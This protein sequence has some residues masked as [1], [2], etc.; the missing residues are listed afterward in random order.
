MNT[1]HIYEVRLR[2]ARTLKLAES[3]VPHQEAARHV[4]QT[5]IGDAD[6][7][8]F[9]AIFLD[10][11][12]KVTGAHVVAIGGQARIGGVEVRTV[13]RAAIA[14]CAT[15]I[16]LGHNHPSGDPGPSKEDREITDALVAAGKLLGL[17]VL[18]HVIVTRDPSRWR[19]LPV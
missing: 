5:M 15:G 13:F 16:I 7:E 3:E 11:H 14:A 6:R 10:V 17:P 8:H 1:V 2:K 18:D 4:I 12:N 9:V 19:A